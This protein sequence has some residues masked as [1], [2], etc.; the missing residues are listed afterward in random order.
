MTEVLRE[1]ALV[2]DALGDYPSAAKHL[3][4]AVDLA[5][6]TSDRGALSRSLLALGSLETQHGHPER[7]LG[8]DR[9]GLRVAERSGDLTEMAH[10][11]IVLGADLT[12]S[13]RYAES[14]PHYSSGLKIARILGNLRLTAY[15]TLNG[16]SAL[17]E[18]HRY[19]EAGAPIR[20]A[21]GYF[22]ILEERDTLALLRTYEGD[23]EMGL[24]HWTRALDEWEQGLKGLRT[25]GSPADLAHV[26]L[27]IARHHVAHNDLERAKRHLVEARS[28]ARRLESTTLL[29]DVEGVLTPLAERRPQQDL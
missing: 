18:L 3:N 16:A 2:E 13:G 4:E 9:E 27:D 7:G 22:E 11:H 12:K 8:Y 17:L 25:Y 5:T 29:S 1:M 21:Q 6:E 10:A 19:E 23:R 14:L 24:G 28:I 26:L 15:A 20:E